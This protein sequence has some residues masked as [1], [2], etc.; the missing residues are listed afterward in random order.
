MARWLLRW[1]PSV[2]VIAVVIGVGYAMT[3][4]DAKEEPYATAS[5]GN[6]GHSPDCLI[7]RLSAG[8]ANASPPGHGPARTH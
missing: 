5:V 8:D 3:T 4:F 7:C 6:V 1:D 2:F